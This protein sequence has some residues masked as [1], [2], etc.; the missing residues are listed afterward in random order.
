MYI[1]EKWGEKFPLGKMT[2][3][4]IK[5]G[6]FVRRFNNVL[7]VIVSFVTVRGPTISSNEH[8]FLLTKSLLI[9]NGELKTILGLDWVM[10]LLKIIYSE[11]KEET[12]PLYVG[13]CVFLPIPG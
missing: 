6:M 11:R 7:I 3:N 12:S 5:K 8:S 4:R 2:V 9:A 10:T 1:K 13:I